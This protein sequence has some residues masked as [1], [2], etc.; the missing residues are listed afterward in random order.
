MVSELTAILFGARGEYLVEVQRFG[1]T[2]NSISR[3][4]WLVAKEETSVL[5]AF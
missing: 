5:S 4:V 1:L 3:V 2:V